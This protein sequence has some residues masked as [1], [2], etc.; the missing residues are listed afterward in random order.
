MLSQTQIDAMLSVAPRV[1]EQFALALLLGVE[2]G[3][4]IGSIRLL[5]WHDVDLTQRTVRWRAESDK[6]GLDHTRPLSDEMAAALRAA[7]KSDDAWVLPSSEDE[8]EPC[9]RRTLL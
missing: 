1:S 8:S 4:R 2:T 3:H 6:I 5:R 9:P 7:K